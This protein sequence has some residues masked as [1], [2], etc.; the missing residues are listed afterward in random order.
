MNSEN[1]NGNTFQTFSTLLAL[2]LPLVQFFFN[3]IPDQTQTIFL[4]KDQFLVVS[5]IAALFAY[6]LIIAFKNTIWF[7]FAFNRWKHKKYQNYTHLI[8]PNVYDEDEIKKAVKAKRVDPPFYLEPTNAYYVLIPTVF[9]L[10]IIF[11]GLGL[12][13]QNT[14]N[15]LLIYLQALTYILLVS[16]TSLT[17]A[18]FYINDTNRR[19]RENINKEKYSR[20]LQLLFDNHALEEYPNIEFLGQGQLDFNS[21]NTVI[22]VNGEKAYN[23]KTDTEANVLQFVELIPDQGASQPPAQQ[24]TEYKIEEENENQ[25]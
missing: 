10:M 24:P 16:L 11:L 6:L 21:L 17:L 12:F 7:R 2:L 9:V 5:V 22:R 14:T 20:V 25:G 19:K 8:D 18:A 13:F 23:I 15:T 4:I 3:F 1:S